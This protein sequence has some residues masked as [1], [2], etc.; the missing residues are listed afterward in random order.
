[1][2]V[3][4]ACELALLCLLSYVPFFQ[5]IFNT[6]PLGIREWLFL[7]IWPPVI[8]YIDEIRKALTR[9][10]EKEAKKQQAKA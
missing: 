6:A 10:R 3:G 5:G 9:R 7:I 2:I 1:M 8:P 4:I